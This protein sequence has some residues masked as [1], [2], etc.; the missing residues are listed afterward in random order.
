MQYKVDMEQVHAGHQLTEGLILA[1]TSQNIC[2]KLTAVSTK[3]VRFFF[4]GNLN[5][6]QEKKSQSWI[7]FESEYL[8][9][10]IPL[11]SQEGEDITNTLML[12]KASSD[13]HGAHPYPY[14]SK[15]PKTDFAACFHLFPLPSQL[16]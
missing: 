5:Y 8:P 7:S 16:T 3:D 15:P 6:S 14:S 10:A 1:Y 9:Q 13:L 2:K 4:S 11:V 12:L